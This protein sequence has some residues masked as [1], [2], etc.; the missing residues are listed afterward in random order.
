MSHPGAVEILDTHIHIAS[1]DVDRYPRQPTGVGSDW[2]LRG[3]FDAEALL[4]SMDEC[5]VAGGMFVQPVGLYGYDNSYTIDAAADHADR[6]RA[7]ICVDMDGDDAPGEIVR[8]GRSAAVTGVRMFGVG[9]RSAWIDKPDAGAAAFEAAATAGLV[10]VLTVFS[11]QLTTLKPLIDR[12]PNVPVAIDHCGFPDLDG[13]VADAGQALFDAVSSPNVS[14]KVSTHLLRAAMET[15]DLTDPA[16]L[17][18]QLA[19]H[20]GAARLMWGSD[21]PQSPRGYDE[22]VDLGRRSCRRL[23]AADQAAYL[24]ASAR[25]LFFSR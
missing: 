14:L 20:F 25:A 24:G 16:D 2:W 13:G 18:D 6:V 7:V 22:M 11:A 19:E 15:Q 10:A 23:S 4:R 1:D 12:F 8:L 21:Y 3:G 17:V 9:G 5:G